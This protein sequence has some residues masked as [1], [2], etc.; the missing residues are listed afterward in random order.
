MSSD[1]E[2]KI[3]QEIAVAKKVMVSEAKAIQICSER[4]D[5]NF[6]KALDI[7]FVTTGKVI[8]TGIGKSGHLAKKL[9]R[10]YVV[11]EHQLHS[12][13]QQKLFM[14]IWAFIS[15][16]IQSFSFLTVELRLN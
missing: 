10:H 14:G 9:L 13:I 2:N 6:T 4:L 7:L 1:I 11:L 5:R 15:N 12:S 16:M 3:S 8:I